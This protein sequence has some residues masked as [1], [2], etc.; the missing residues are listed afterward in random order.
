MTLVTDVLTATA[1]AFVLASLV[2]VYRIVVGPTIPDRIIA[3][4]NAG[5]NIVVVIV[6]LAAIFEDPGAL[7]I[8]LV[9]ALL[10]YLLSIAFSKFTIE[11]EVFSE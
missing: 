8:A 7:D 3:L 5:S 6:L 2:A 10:N 9:F 1:G 11:R 4:N